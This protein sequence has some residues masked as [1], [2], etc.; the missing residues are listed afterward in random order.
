VALFKREPKQ[1]NDKPN[2]ISTSYPDQPQPEEPDGKHRDH[3][4]SPGWDVEY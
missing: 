2:N 1:D 3:K 4:S